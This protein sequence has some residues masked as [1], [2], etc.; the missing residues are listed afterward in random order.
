MKVETCSETLSRLGADNF[1]EQAKSL[2]LAAT[3]PQRAEQRVAATLTAAKETKEPEW[4]LLL[5]IHGAGGQ[6]GA[7]G[8]RS[9]R[10]T[11]FSALGK[12]RWNATD[13]GAYYAAARRALGTL[14]DTPAIIVTAV[15]AD[16]NDDAHLMLY[17]A[18]PETILSCGGL[19]EHYLFY[20]R[21]SC[22]DVRNVVQAGLT[23][24]ML[25]LLRAGVLIR[26]GVWEQRD[27]VQ[28]RGAPETWALLLQR[29]SEALDT[30]RAITAP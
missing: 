1:P 8:G 5:D 17:S 13:G 21:E 4:F 14:L 3:A 15:P 2:I 30:E 6:L 9:Q 12:G 27:G 22:V 25:A 18:R 19:E 10:A 28:F 23:D 16:E 26:S 11:P 20:D 29:W 7:G 24:N